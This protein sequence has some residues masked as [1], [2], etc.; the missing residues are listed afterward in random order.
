M[1]YRAPPARAVRVDQVGDRRD[2]A[3]LRQCLDDKRTFPKMVLGKRPVLQRAAA[4]GAEML[5]DRRGALVAGFVD[6]QQMPS[7]GMAGDALDGDGFRREACRARRPRLQACRR[8][9]RRDGQAAKW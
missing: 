3:G 6:M 7:V 1:K 9:R 8:R 5:A 4:A 2:D